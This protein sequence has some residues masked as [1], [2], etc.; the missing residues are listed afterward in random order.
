MNIKF[1]KSDLKK[2]FEYILGLD[3]VI[4]LAARMVMQS[5]RKW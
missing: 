3:G 5:S 2:D 4:S 1:L